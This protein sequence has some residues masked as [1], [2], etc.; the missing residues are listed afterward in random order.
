MENICIKLSSGKVVEVQALTAR[1]QM[2]ADVCSKGVPVQLLYY[3][4]AMAITKIGDEAIPKATSDIDL[5]SV[6]DRLSGQD[7]DEI[8]SAYGDEF[9]PNGEVIKNSPS[10]LSASS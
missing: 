8:G 4:V 3:R 6:I 10:P 2:F 7:I 9:A 5:D 1:E